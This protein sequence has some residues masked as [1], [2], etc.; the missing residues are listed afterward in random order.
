MGEGG[1]G[2][3]FGLG[4]TIYG[5][6]KKFSIRRLLP[7]NPKEA[8]ADSKNDDAGQH[9]EEQEEEDPLGRLHLEEQQEVR[10]EGGEG[11]SG[12]SSPL[13]LLLILRAGVEQGAGGRPGRRA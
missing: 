3:T 12:S 4:N 11:G 13:L 6:D 10:V 9:A 5:T 2:K 8:H 1:G 7:V